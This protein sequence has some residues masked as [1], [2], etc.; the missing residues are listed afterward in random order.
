MAN[1]NTSADRGVPVG[2]WFHVND[3]TEA[4][5]VVPVWLSRTASWATAMVAGAYASLRSRVEV[6]PLIV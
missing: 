5:P 2:T 4:T 1:V 6:V 3:A